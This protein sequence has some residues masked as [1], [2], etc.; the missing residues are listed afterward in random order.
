MTMINKLCLTAV[1]ALIV[2]APALAQQPA[3]PHEGDYYTPSKTVVQQPTP[4][5]ARQVK[6]GDYY[7][8]SNGAAQQPTTQEL[9]QAH[10]G[11]YYA[12]KKNQ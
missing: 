8:P 3:Q 1:L 4:Q 9:Q 12:P 10:E 11:D 5:A 6:D 7:A 2:A